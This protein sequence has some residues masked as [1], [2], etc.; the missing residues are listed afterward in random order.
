MKER[1][2]LYL[3]ELS[4]NKVALLFLTNMNTGMKIKAQ[5]KRFRC[6]N[7]KLFNHG[8]LIQVQVAKK[9]K[10]PEAK[11]FPAFFSLRSSEVEG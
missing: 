6:Q 2:G 10:G 3:W 9:R 5:K 8:Q 7:E 11:A 4:K 1:G